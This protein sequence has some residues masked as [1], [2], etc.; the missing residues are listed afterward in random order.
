MINRRC[1]RL[2]LTTMMI[3][4]EIKRLPFA[5]LYP[6]NKLVNREAMLTSF[7][8]FPS[9]KPPP[10]CHGAW[11]CGKLHG[12]EILGILSRP[13][14]EPMKPTSSGIEIICNSVPATN[15]AMQLLDIMIK[16]TMAAAP[17]PGTVSRNSFCVP[18]RT[19][20]RRFHRSHRGLER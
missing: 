6:I 13:S 4:S 15:D 3:L 2:M 11:L 10:C 18:S 16:V 14:C 12:W 9:Y 8:A 1:H 5:S 20:P 17:A 7:Q 19:P